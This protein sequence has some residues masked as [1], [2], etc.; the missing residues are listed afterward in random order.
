M[1]RPIFGRDRDPGVVMSLPD[2][3]DPYA[4]KPKVARA[5]TRNRMVDFYGPG[6]EGARCGT[7][8]HLR[9]YSYARTYYKCDQ[10]R[11]SSSVVT[12]HRVRWPACALYQP[13]ASATPEAAPSTITGEAPSKAKATRN[14]LPA[15]NDTPGARDG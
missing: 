2:S 3:S 12:D 5:W 10:R 11:M 7:C 9:A 15:A 4:G 1:T 8:L 6:P 14:A 13:E